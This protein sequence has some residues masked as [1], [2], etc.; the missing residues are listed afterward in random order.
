M[1]KIGTLLVC[2]ILSLGIISP[3]KTEAATNQQ[4]EYYDDGS[5]FVTVIEDETPEITPLST[6]VTKSKTG[7]YYNSAGN[8]LWSVKV[9]G[10]FS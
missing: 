7:S 1:K 8:I 6:T 3:V 9:T 4:I 2:L 10:T 5:Y